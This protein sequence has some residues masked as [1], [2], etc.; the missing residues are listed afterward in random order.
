MG[1]HIQPTWRTVRQASPVAGGCGKLGS[2][3]P[4]SLVSINWD[5]LLRL[6][7]IFSALNVVHS[8]L[9]GQHIQPTWRTVRQASPVAGG[10]GKLGSINPL[11]LVSINWDN[12]L[13]LHMLV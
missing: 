4:L 9:M 7:R 5:N 8:F 1:Q 12:L 6:E 13:R 10:C 3:N 11:S 2:I